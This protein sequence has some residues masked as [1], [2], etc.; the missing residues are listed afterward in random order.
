MVVMWESLQRAGGA[1]TFAA[2]VCNPASFGQTV[3]NIFTLSFLV[4]RLGGG[5]GGVTA[6]L[7][8]PPA[9]APCPQSLPWA[10]SRWPHSCAPRRLV[11]PWGRAAARRRA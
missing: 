8:L 7:P 9:A 4:G 6:P 3:E 2:L 10:P 1:A 5:P 11:A